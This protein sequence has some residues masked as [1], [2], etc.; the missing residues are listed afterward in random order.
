MRKIVILGAAESGVG[1]AILAQKQ[2]FDVFVSDK[3]MIKPHYKDMLDSHHIEWEEGRHSEERILMA[4]EVVKSPGIPKEVPMVRKIVERGIPVVSE[5]EF[6]GRYTDAK[7]VC[8]TGSNGKTTTTSLTYHIFREAGLDVGLA[9]NIG[10]SL[11]LQVAETPHEWYVIELSS[12]QL[13]DMFDFRANIAVLLNITPDHLDRYDFCFDKYAAAKMRILQN[14]THDDAFIYWAADPVIQKELTRRTVTAQAC[15]FE[16]NEA[17]G[18]AGFIRNGQYVLTAPTPFE[19]PRAELSLPGRHNLYNML[20]AGLAANQAGI[21]HEVIRRCLGDF[22]GV[23]HR[24]EKVCTAHGV[25]YVND[26]KATN[27]DACYWALE[28][29]TTPT[30]L[31]L[32]GLDK[33]NDYEPLKPLISEKCRAL[34]YMG[35]DNRKLHESFDSMGLPV[36]DTA[37]MADC[38]KA[39]VGFAKEGDTV[40]LSPCCAS[41]DLFKNMEDRGEQFKAIARTL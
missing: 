25:H 33:G 38:M 36:A 28:S 24:L 39:C 11:A 37:S 22:P 27:V 2:G 5:I 18:L 7:M 34:V 19:M 20:A 12:F 15:P 1:A 40:L 17:E 32:G 30:V 9:G 13:D 14:Q 35:V 26:S 3:S 29:M 23:E 10:H 8:I 16:I 21:S 4:D 41:F 31:I 6:A